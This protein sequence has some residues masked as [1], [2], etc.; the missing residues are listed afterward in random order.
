MRATL[1][2]T[3]CLVIWCSCLWNR[4]CVAV[5]ELRI[6]Y[7]ERL[8][9]RPMPLA[10]MSSGDDGRVKSDGIFVHQSAATSS[11]DLEV[12]AETSDFHQA[13]RR[14]QSQ[15]EHKSTTELTN[16]SYLN[17]CMGPIPLYTCSL[18][19]CGHNIST[20]YV[21]FVFFFSICVCVCVCVWVW[22]LSSSFF[23]HSI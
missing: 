14:L 22:S 17:H 20:S 7:E 19:H 13:L 10:D 21:F 15:D 16:C 6:Q 4:N 12:G 11:L 23:S 3:L 18:D 8:L 1:V 5:E 2:N 9:D